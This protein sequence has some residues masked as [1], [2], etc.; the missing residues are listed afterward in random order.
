MRG[1]RIIR[2]RDNPAVPPPELPAIT[3]TGARLKP[4]RWIVLIIALCA[5]ALL[6]DLGKRGP[7][8]WMEG[9]A[10]LS[11]RETWVKHHNGV[12]S[13]WLI[14]TV[15]DAPRLRKPPL[16]VW[17]TMS[18]WSD[19]DPRK[20]DAQQLI[21]RARM[22]TVA[23]SMLLVFSVYWIGRSLQDA[24]YGLVAAIVAG[25]T[26]LLFN[27]GRL[28]TYDMQV[29][30]WA[31]LGSAAGLWA[32][33]PFDDQLVSRMRKFACVS[34]WIMGGI[35]T[36]AAILTKAPLCAALAILPIAGT[37]A[38]DRARMISRCAGLLLMTAVAIAVSAWWFL[39]A[40]KL[41]PKLAAVISYEMQLMTP[42]PRPWTYYFTQL[43]WLAL[44]WTIW[45]VIGV[46]HPFMKSAAGVSPHRA[47]R[48]TIWIWFIAMIVALSIPAQKERR[49]LAFALPAM[50]LLIAQVFRDQIDAKR[51]LMDDPKTRIVVDIHWGFMIAIGASVGSMALGHEIWVR[52]YWLRG[53]LVDPWPWPPALAISIALV[54]IAFWG[55]RS[56]RQCKVPQAM[57]AMLLFGSIAAF[58]YVRAYS[59]ARD[60]MQVVASD[61]IKVRNA[62]GDAPLYALR[63]RG[64]KP[65]SY[66]FLFYAG[67]ISDV[68]SFNRA[69]KESRQ[70][71]LFLCAEDVEHDVNALK[72]AG[73]QNIMTF[74]D[75][76]DRLQSLW[77]GPAPNPTQQ[78]GGEHQ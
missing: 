34:C 44:P 78:N 77:R 52:K 55:W 2:F 66:E 17:L 53:P 4:I 28:A 3:S 15:R 69:K 6:I 63:Q 31:A 73:F 36:G 39:L 41:H 12:E 16:L 37:M 21:A 65:L 54:G 10:L 61:A 35:A 23:L 27:Q 46:I 29:T 72:Q 58:C 49:Y 51:S 38:F 60:S 50:S 8:Q 75:L 14:P 1:A 43:W 7:E 67:R 40:D 42:E 5:P 18:A 74:H 62:I 30:A 24:T 64:R 13:A 70:E 19:L 22:V 57:V 11:S 33:R 47:K 59:N 48:W 32:I 25:T 68:I 56:H 20:A 45:L 9:I 26:L 71:L 76:P